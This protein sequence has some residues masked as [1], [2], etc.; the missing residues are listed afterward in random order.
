M[1]Y[2]DMNGAS[3]L[4]VT[5]SVT[6]IPEHSWISTGGELY[7]TQILGIEKGQT[8]KPGV[9]S[10]VIYYGKGTKL[11]DVT[12]TQRKESMEL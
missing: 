3:A 9:M 6:A 1:T 7:E 12:E 8:G 11:G 5:G 2:V 4:W 10:G